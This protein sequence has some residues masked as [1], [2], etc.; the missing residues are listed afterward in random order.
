VRKNNLCKRSSEH[1]SLRNGIYRRKLRSPLAVTSL[2]PALQT[3][4]LTGGSTA[5]N[6]YVTI[7]GGIVTTNEMLRIQAVIDSRTSQLLLNLLD[8]QEGGRTG[9]AVAV[10]ANEEYIVPGFSGSGVSSL[11]MR[12]YNYDA[13]VDLIRNN[14]AGRLVD[15]LDIN[16]S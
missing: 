16:L 13:L 1:G 5:I 6:P 12:V 4:I 3:G 2:D 10:L 15:I 8:M 7:F 9:T 11:S 14:Y